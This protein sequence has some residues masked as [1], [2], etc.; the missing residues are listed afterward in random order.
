MGHENQMELLS[1]LALK[2][3]VLA[4]DGPKCLVSYW[5]TMATIP[6]WSPE[7]PTARP[8]VPSKDPGL[9]CVRVTSETCVY[10]PAN[11]DAYMAAASRLHVG[12]TPTALASKLPDLHEHPIQQ[13]V[14][15]T[16]TP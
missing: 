16:L 14:P 11:V 10:V 5:G 2:A 4:D 3:D 7:D 1:L 15:R 8:S 13:P 9:L 6:M 12:S